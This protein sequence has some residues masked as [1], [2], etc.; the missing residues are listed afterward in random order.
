MPL[1]GQCGMHWEVGTDP[2]CPKCPL[3][4]RGV[5]TFIYKERETLF[6]VSYARDSWRH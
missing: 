6:N 3:R 5:D 4:V 2:K 1:C